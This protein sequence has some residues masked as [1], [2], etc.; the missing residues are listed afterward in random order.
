MAFVQRFT[1]YWQNNKCIQF[2]QKSRLHCKPF[3]FKSIFIC[4]ELYKYEYLRASFLS[5]RCTSFSAFFPT[6]RQIHHCQ[7][8]KDKHLSVS[9][10]FSF[11]HYFSKKKRTLNTNAFENPSQRYLNNVSFVFVSINTNR[12]RCATITIAMR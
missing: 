2:F 9:R 11:K 6:I 3:F 4:I 8:Q 12:L 5:Q 1:K 7:R 10:I